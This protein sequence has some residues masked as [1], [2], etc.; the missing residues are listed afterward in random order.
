MLSTDGIVVTEF[1]YPDSIKSPA[2]DPPATR[3]SPDRAV[4]VSGSS[5]NLVSSGSVAFS[6][7]VSLPS[8][9]VAAVAYAP[10]AAPTLGK[11]PNCDDCLMS[12][13]PMGFN[14][15]F[16]GKVYDKINI[17][18]NGIVGFGDYMRDGCCSGSVIP[19]NDVN[20]NIIA[21]GQS[22]WVP[23]RTTSIRYETRG[24][25]PN[26][27]FLIQFLDVMESSGSGVMTV[28]LVLYE[29]SNDIVI[30]TK[31]LST[32]IKSHV[33][34]QGI[35]NLTGGEAE[36]IPGRVAAKY[37]LANDAVKFSVTA[38][39]K[40]PVI[41]AP[42]DISVNTGTALCAA[43]VN[44]GT[45]TATDDAPGVAVSGVRS[46][47]LAL[48]AAYPK[49][50]TTITWTATDVETV[51]SS[52]TQ[53]ITVS[54]KENPSVIAPPNKSVRT[55]KGVSYAVV[56]VGTAT[57]ADNCP[58]VTVTGARSDN[59]PLS[60]G[61]PLGVTTITWTAK[62]AAGNL[63]TANQ[64]VTVSANQPPVFPTAPP[65]IAVNTDPG[66]C[67]AVLNPGAPVATDDLEGG[68]VTVTGVRNDAKALNGPYPKGLTVITWT[69]TDAED[70]TASVTQSVTVSDKEKPSIAAPANISVGNDP[71][72]ASATV[73]AGNPDAKDNCLSVSV[74]SARSDGLSL[75]SPYPIGSTTITWKATDPSLNFSTASQT[76]VVRDVTP[77]TVSVPASFSVNATSSRGAEVSFAVSA[78]DNVGVTSLSCS[79]SSGS[80]FPI[81]V[82]SVDCSASDAAGNRASASF[83]VTVLGAEDQLVKLI[84]YVTSLGLPNG[85]A[86]PLLNQLNAALRAL[87][88][89][90]HISCIKLK[91]FINLLDTKASKA[92]GL[93][94]QAFKKTSSVSATQQTQAVGDA[95]RICS[96]LGCD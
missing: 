59:A 12:N 35:E 88:G 14:F 30:Y 51:K 83:K 87:N 90:S 28:Q 11:G 15:T 29:Q 5:A 2:I 64:T 80:Q 39:N 26:R 94:A 4:G 31:T 82:T 9:T 95:Q 77:P 65:A 86:Q 76:V 33:L 16:F 91:D 68:A 96:V 32:S 17:G 37:A 73:A 45:A 43:N 41:T 48:D 20:N 44:V 23:N 47:G 55:N 69:A 6:A 52:A 54:D 18:S 67:Y 92:D 13:I 85:T 40:A 57:A 56:D 22:D 27:R 71:G 89:N 46:D 36:F 61:F 10:E 60:A 78:S 49:G 58:N 34:T 74:S 3:V 53:T 25:A 63:G 84:A 93:A 1:Q 7:V 19:L 24:S 8:Y 50:V 21:L 75:A 66:V 62:D 81:G 72:L 38:T 70:A 42:A 79:P